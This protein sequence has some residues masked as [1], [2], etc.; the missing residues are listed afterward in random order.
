MVNERQIKQW[1][2]TFE[3]AFEWRWGDSP[4]KQLHFGDLGDACFPHPLD[5]KRW[6]LSWQVLRETYRNIIFQ[7][8]L[9]GCHILVSSIFLCCYVYIYVHEQAA[10]WRPWSHFPQLHSRCSSCLGSEAARN[11]QMEGTVDTHTHAIIV[12]IA[13]RVG[14]CNLSKHSSLFGVWDS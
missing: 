3:N 11:Q 13:Y 6:T 7:L 12:H 10:V 8:K 4:R 5:N 14:D 1:L 9:S 2:M